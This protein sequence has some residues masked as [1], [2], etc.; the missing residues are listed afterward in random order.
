MKELDKDTY[1]A[2]V[3]ESDGLILV[4][5]WSESCEECQEIMPDIEA[6]ERD[7]TGKV[8]V[9]KVNIT[10]NRRLAIR[11]RVMG[12]PSVLI[13]KDGTQIASF[14]QEIDPDDV[15]AKLDEVLGV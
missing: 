7:Y 8:G 15:R 9:A 11:E 1:D 5:F 6:I 4:D 14:S 3:I 10:G 12:L 2:E 13:Y